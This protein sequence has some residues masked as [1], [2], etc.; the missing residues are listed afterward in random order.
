MSSVSSCA[1]IG[2]LAAAGVLLTGDA[3]QAALMTSKGTGQEQGAAVWL[4]L[5]AF[6][7]ATLGLAFW[8]SKRRETE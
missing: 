8:N 2:A 6:V 7:I 5:A 1:R 4:C 3:A